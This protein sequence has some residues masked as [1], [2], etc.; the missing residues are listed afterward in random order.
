MIYD[1]KLKKDKDGAWYR[2]LGMNEKGTKQKFRLGKEK[3]EAKRRMHLILALYESQIEVAKFYDGS[4]CPEHLN[5]AK[6]IAK[7][8]KAVLPRTTLKVNE[9]DFVQ[10]SGE[11]YVKTL[12]YLNRDGENFQPEDPVDLSEGLHAIETAQKRNRLVRAKLEGTNPDRDPTGQTINEAIDAFVDHLITQ[13]TQPDGSLS[14]WGKTQVNQVNSWRRYMSITTET[15]NGKT[16]SLNLLNT[17]LADLTVARAQQMIDAT[18]KRPLTVE[19]KQTRRMAPGTARS[20][21][22]KIKEFF[23]WLDLSDEWQWWEPP[24]FRKLKYKVSDLTHDEKHERK[25][26]KEKWRISDEEIQ[27]LVNY[28]TP[29]ERVLL[30]LG[31]NCAFGAGE[32]G[33]LRIP[34][35]KFKTNEIDGIRFKTGSDTRH[36]L[37]PETVDALKWELRRREQLTKTAESK[38]IFFLTQKGG[39]PLWRKSKSGNYINGI[40]KRW[41]DL[42][43][44]V[45]KDYPNF[46]RYSFGKLRK[47]AAI[48]VIE[49]TDAEAAS[50]ILAHGIPSEDKILA[51][52]V[53]IPWQKLYTAQ[54]AY[55]ETVRPLLDA[56]RPPFEQPAK[57]YIGNK[58]DG[59]LDQYGKGIPVKQIAKNLEISVMTVYRHIDRAGLRTERK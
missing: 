34:Y 7:G 24:R 38:D 16:I 13:S 8:K 21:N 22:K 54:K 35:V 45:C 47:T 49:L 40:A 39:N 48:R 56:R 37:W 20:I 27:T 32:I 2:W 15:R 41:S 23:D 17:D 30:L 3:A 14:P 43:D 25:L 59:I 50:M 6:Q 26:K 1:T 51:A 5:A 53:S 46:H 4:W 19:S 33:N 29:A 36:H 9:I 31:L 44:R 12:A 11:T 58:V 10:A 28:A 55:G 52:Y 57:N 18:K 42:M